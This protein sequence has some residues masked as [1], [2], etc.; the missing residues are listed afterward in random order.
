MFYSLSVKLPQDPEK[1]E[2]LLLINKET[3]EKAE[4]ETSEKQDNMVIFKKIIINTLK[5]EF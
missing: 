1:P 4:E 2:T 5:T 3:P